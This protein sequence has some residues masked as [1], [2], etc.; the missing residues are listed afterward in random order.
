VNL[1]DGKTALQGVIWQERGKWLVLLNP[2]LLRAREARVQLDGEVAVLISE[3][4]FIQLE[5]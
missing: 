5:T 2:M 1:R 3:I 4:Q